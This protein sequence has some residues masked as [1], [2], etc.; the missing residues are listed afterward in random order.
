MSNSAKKVMSK[1][2][3]IDVFD[4]ALEVAH[5]DWQAMKDKPTHVTRADW[6]ENRAGQYLR[7]TKDWIKE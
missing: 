2:R 1:M 5:D 7:E 6:T 4:A 3:L